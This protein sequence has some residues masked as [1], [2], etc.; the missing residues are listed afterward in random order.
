MRTALLAATAAVVLASSAVATA[1]S[2][3]GAAAPGSTPSSGG[4]AYGAPV[5]DATSVGPVASRFSVSPT[6]VVSGAALPQLVLRV[7]EPGVA[8][9]AARVVLLP[10]T[11][12]ASVVRLDLGRVATGRVLRPAW[13]PGTVLR[14]G[15][16]LVRVHAT[17]PL[18]RV[19]VRRARTSGRAV[20]RVTAAPTAPA[21]IPS[22]APALAVAPPAPVGPVA[23]LTPLSPAPAPSATGTFPVRG[24]WRFGDL[25]GAARNGYSHQ[26]VDI[27]AAGGT[28]IVAPV[29]G[30]I[31]FTGYQASA[32]GYYVVQRTPDGRAFFYAHC[33]KGSVVVAQDQAVAQG[34]PLCEVGSTGDATGPH[35]HFELWPA[36]WRDVKGAQPSDPLAV[37]RSWAQLG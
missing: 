29:A 21:P 33:R 10:L 20:L 13:R 15:S 3:G 28:P 1:A 6:R 25:F 11:R 16:Y 36:G 34:A 35:L 27:Q 9:V 24:A 26:G 18:G 19:L 22:A 31:A 12:G 37:L 30:T 14:A 23:V 17:D 8:A 4:V 5:A 2:P 7:D 32:A